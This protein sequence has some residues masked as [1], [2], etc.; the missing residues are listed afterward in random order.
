MMK[1]EKLTLSELKKMEEGEIPMT[2]EGRNQLEKLKLQLHN[3]PTLT[4]L[5][6]AATKGLLIPNTH[7]S[8]LAKLGDT[9]VS[10]KLIFPKPY[11]PEFF[12][13][14]QERKA[15]A[16]QMEIHREA[17]RTA[18]SS[19]ASVASQ[20]QANQ[21][22]IRKSVASFSFALEKIRFDNS[23]FVQVL[24]RIQNDPVLKRRFDL[25]GEKEKVIRSVIN[26]WKDHLIHQIEHRPFDTFAHQFEYACYELLD[27]ARNNDQLAAIS[28][29]DFVNALRYIAEKIVEDGKTELAEWKRKRQT[30]ILHEGKPL[31]ARQKVLLVILQDGPPFERQGGSNEY[32]HYLKLCKRSDRTGYANESWTKA[33]SLIKDY[34]AVSHLLTA[35]QKKKAD[36]ETI[37]IRAGR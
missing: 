31:S 13:N 22:T 20:W 29:Q 25:L 19:L 17:M 23:Q 9:S 7:T 6:A 24:Q 26:K 14:P 34:E 18:V 5:A 2:E 12:T 4:A 30:K 28:E 27:D 10:N 1:P 36:D 3:L 15:F 37:I 33:K 35:S 16:N 32:N 8:I 21:E 11:I